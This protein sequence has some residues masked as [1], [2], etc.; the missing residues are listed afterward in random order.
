MTGVS[1]GEEAPVC[2]GYCGY[3]D[4]C[5]LTDII[6]GSIPMDAYVYGCCWR[7][8]CRVRGLNLAEIDAETWRDTCRE[9]GHAITELGW[10]S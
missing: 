8:I 1:Y 5:I 3:S 2:S 9:R 7:E 6:K 10:Q 4:Q